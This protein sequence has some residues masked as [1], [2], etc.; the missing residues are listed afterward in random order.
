MDVKTAG[1][2]V[3]LFEVFANARTPLTLSEIARGLDAPQSSCFNLVRALEA[4]GF[5]YSVGGR[6]RVYPTRKLFDM[7]EAIVSFDPLVPRVQPVLEKL[8][9]QTQE[10]TIFGTQKGDGVVYLA[11]AEGQQTIRYISR[12]GEL[13]PIHSSSIG[14]ALLSFMPPAD[15]QKLIKRV[16]K[17]EIT[18]KT[19][20]TI[21]ALEAEIELTQKRGY[22]ITRGENV[23]DVM[24][25]A[26]PFRI[27]DVAYAIA[28]AGPIGRMDDEKAARYAEQTR[29]L[30][31]GIADHP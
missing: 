29:A 12:A 4:R 21:D 25:V 26:T 13:K 23:P 3:D 31:A 14:K 9:D 6:K 15:R 11:V 8:R 10:T 20:T 19:I 18:P 2:T 30:T 5:L 27:D 1:R 24:A 28:V 17:P 16:A 7:A 22:A